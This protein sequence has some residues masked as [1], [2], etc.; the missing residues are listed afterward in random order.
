MVMSFP[1]LPLEPKDDVIIGHCAVC[2]GEVYEGE[3]CWSDGNEKICEEHL[4]RM[5]AEHFGFHQ[6]DG[7]EL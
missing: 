1:E 6:T 3:V 2:G 5:T 7:A 4:D